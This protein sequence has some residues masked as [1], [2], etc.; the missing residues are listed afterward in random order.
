MSESGTDE[1]ETAE[2]KALIARCEQAGDPESLWIR[3][4]LRD[5]LAAKRR[6]RVRSRAAPMHRRFSIHSQKCRKL[7]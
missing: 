3:R 7:R 2:L 6:G 5:A 1:N 4:L